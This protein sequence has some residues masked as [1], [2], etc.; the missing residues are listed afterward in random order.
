MPNIKGR[1]QSGGLRRPIP[2][3]R[4]LIPGMHLDESYVLQSL[5][6]GAI[7]YLSEDSPREDVLE[8]IRSEAEGRS[9]SAGK[10]IL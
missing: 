3:Q 8:A 9:S 10:I 2:P 1:G 7:A 6:V 5:R 4:G